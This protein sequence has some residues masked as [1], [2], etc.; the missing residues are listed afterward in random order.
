MLVS[1]CFCLSLQFST[2]EVALHKIVNE[3]LCI[4]LLPETKIL[5]RLCKTCISHLEEYQDLLG[6]LGTVKTLLQV[7]YKRGQEALETRTSM[8]SDFTLLKN[9]DSQGMT[10]LIYQTKESDGTVPQLYIS[11]G[12][13]KMLEIVDDQ[14]ENF[15]ELVHLTTLTDV[16]PKS[17]FERTN[18]SVNYI[19]KQCDDNSANLYDSEAIQLHLLA[20]HGYSICLCN[21][22]DTCFNDRTELSLHKVECHSQIP[23]LVPLSKELRCKICDKTF[24]DKRLFEEHALAHTDSSRPF[25]CPKEGCIKD[26]TS[27]YTLTSHMKIHTDRPRPYKCTLCEKSFYHSQNLVQHQK[28]HSSTKEYICSNCNKAFSTQHNLDVHFIVHTK[29][30]KFACVMC[31][32][33]FARK[34]EVRDHERTHTGE[35]PFGCEFC[36]ATFAQRSNLLSHKRATHLNDKRHKCIQCNKGF[37]RRRLLDYHIKSTHTGERPFACSTCSATFVIPEHFKKHMRIHSGKKPF[38]CELCKRSFTSKDNLKAHRFVHSK[39]KPYECVVCEMGYMRKTLLF[40]H[41][42]SLGH[43]S[44]HFIVNEPKIGYEGTIEIEKTL[45]KVELINEDHG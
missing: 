32:K 40:A 19:C 28:L 17:L 25:K 23:P 13:D 3:S 22:C 20:E 39:Q 30:K 2:D 18:N 26:F 34:A 21:I 41:M 4:E 6:R 44:D 14:P 37:K 31:D 29:L 1:L 12:R 35:K 36:N 11:D 24:K 15:D 8:K 10:Y 38:V 42:K 43:D 45:M 9:E 33:T 5:E 16:D 27:K 7:A